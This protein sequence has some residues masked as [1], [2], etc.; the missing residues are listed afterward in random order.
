MTK[1]DIG[2]EPMDERY[3]ELYKEMRASG[4][5]PKDAVIKTHELYCFGE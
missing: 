5:S 3:W 2:S 1:H 4:L